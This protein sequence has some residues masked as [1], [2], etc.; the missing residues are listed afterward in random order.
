M[1]LP[2]RAGQLREN[3]R[4]GLSTERM[5]AQ[6]IHKRVDIH[7]HILP[8]RLPDL[9]KKY[10]YNGWIS[11][12]ELPD[13]KQRMI[14]DG[15]PFRDIECNCWDAETRIDEIGTDVIQ[16]LSTI[17]VLFNYWAEPEHCLDLAKYLN[18]DIASTCSQYPQKFIGL[19]TLPMQSPKLAVQE[20][21]RCITELG[22]AGIQ[23]GSH[24]NDWNLDAAELE[25]VWMA[26]EDLDCPIFVHPWDMEQKGRMSK[27][28][29]PWLI[30][31]PCETTVAICS[32]IFGGVLER[33]PKLRFC[34]AHAGGSFPFTIGRI[35]HGFNVMN[36]N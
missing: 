26:C 21:H 36:L 16:V 3:R 34:F 29:F 1:W 30:G 9:S 2:Q 23:I 13:G 11:T 5:T 17:P 18:D 24:I 10:G 31:M 28:W 12:E 15:K 32:L 14:L 35:E 27:Y 33:H 22:M 6:S 7:T 25:P 20:L 4:F 19:A 8:R